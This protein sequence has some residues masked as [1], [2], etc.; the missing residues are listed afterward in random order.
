MPVRVAPAAVAAVA[1]GML[2]IACG[3]GSGGAPS[4]AP[5]G[6]YLSCLREHGVNLPSG[7]PRPSGPR[8]S[9]LRPSGLRPSGGFPPGGFRPSGAPPGV[10]QD[11][12]ERA[13]QACVALRPS[14]NPSRLR[15]N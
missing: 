10:D 12:L 13:M 9:G 3:G 7:R 1:V 15:D 11:T 8:P 2:L 6:D 14:A 4:A 5:T